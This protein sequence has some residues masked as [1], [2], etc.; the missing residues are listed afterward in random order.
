M[1]QPRFPFV[2]AFSSIGSIGVVVALAS[3]S[4]CAFT[5]DAD[6]PDTFV[7]GQEVGGDSAL[8]QPPVSAFDTP[9]TKDVEP[10]FT[11][12]AKPYDAGAMSDAAFEAGADGGAPGGE[13]I[14][15]GLKMYSFGSGNTEVL[16]GA[17]IDVFFGNAINGATPDLPGVIADDKG[18]AHV[19]A[20]AGWRIAY[21]IPKTVDPDPT[22]ALES[23][24]LYDLQLP[25]DPGAS[26]EATGLTT[27]ES[28]TLK[29]AIAGD[30]TYEP[31]A[32][33][34]IFATRIVDCQRRFL[35]NATLE[36]F[37]LDT[38]ANVSPLLSNNCASGAPC[39][40]YLGDNE[41]PDLTLPWSSRSGLVVVANLDAKHHYR[42]IAKGK[43]TGS[44]SF[45]VVGQRDIELQVGAIDVA[46]VYP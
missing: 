4:A 1:R 16:P 33:T 17:P 46:Y 27:A 34:A 22:K 39:R 21:R 32:G 18:I 25:F 20:P 35:R 12:K 42:A 24:V 9:T 43:L 11:C 26:V 8:E 10:D 28:R 44:T 38:G 30:A 29:L 36:V 2:I 19:R 15:L 40:I 13:L 23:Y 31:P 6:Q 5:H 41:F 3:G 14:D 7:P 45:E 37:D